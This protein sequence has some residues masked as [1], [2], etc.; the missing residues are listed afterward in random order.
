M[1]AARRGPERTSSRARSRVASSSR[2]LPGQGWARRASMAQG[3]SSMA[4]RRSSGGRCAGPRRCAARA[5]RGRR[6]GC[7]CPSRWRPGRCRRG[8]RAAGAAT[9]PPGQPVVQVVAEAAVGHRAST[10]SVGQRD[11]VHRQARLILGLA[12]PPA[13]AG[14]QQPQQ[15]LLHARAAA[16]HL[17]DHQRAAVG[18]LGRALSAALAHSAS[19]AASS[20]K[21]VTSSRTSG[22]PG[23]ISWCSARARPSLPVPG[24]AGEQEVRA[25]GAILQPLD[26]VEDAG[27]RR[28]GPR[29]ADERADPAGRP[30][31]Q[32]LQ[33]GGWPSGTRTRPRAARAPPSSGTGAIRADRQPPQP[34]RNRAA[35][36][37]SPDRRRGRGSSRTRSRPPSGPRPPAGPAVPAPGRMLVW[38]RFSSTE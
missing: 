18:L 12:H 24:L 17:L 14:L 3:S 6:P 34:R 37:W 23:E 31:I 11:G 10:S 2:K 4:R 25:E 32:R 21:P 9:A 20:G 8:A 26:H 15:R 29:D 13:P 35:G 7:G 28:V 19:S 30:R 5:V 36:P 38:Y 27:H 16:R 33:A 1:S 22:P